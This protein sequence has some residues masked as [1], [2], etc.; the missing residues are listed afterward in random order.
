MSE[1]MRP[2]SVKITT[3]Q[4]VSLDELLRTQA[5]PTRSEAIRAEIIDFIRRMKGKY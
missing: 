3:D 4:L 2:L 5:F 1:N